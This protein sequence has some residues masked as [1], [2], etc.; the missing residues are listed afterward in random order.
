[1]EAII[2]RD[3]FIGMIENCWHS[4]LGRFLFFAH[5]L[6]ATALVGYYWNH[7]YDD[8][9]GP[10]ICWRLI[11]SVNWPLM[12]ILRNGGFYT[13]QPHTRFVHTLWVFILS[14]P[15]WGYG[16]FAETAAN[17]IRRHL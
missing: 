15:W 2:M 17:S 8:T 4:R 16:R 7:L 12:D 5:F 3:P 6:F 14:I 9:H 1:M 11:Y 13:F 10:L